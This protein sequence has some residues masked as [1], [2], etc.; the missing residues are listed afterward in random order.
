MRFATCG[1][2]FSMLALVATLAA[3]GGGGADPSG[4]SGSTG[5]SSSSGSTGNVVAT[6]TSGKLITFDREDPTKAKTTIQIAGLAKGE[7]ITGLDQNPDDNQFYAITN[8]GAV[9]LLDI[10]SGVATPLQEMQPDLSQIGNAFEGLPTGPIGANF[11]PLTGLMQIVTGD[12]ENFLLNVK[13]G[14]VLTGKGFNAGLTGAGFSDSFKGGGKIKFAGLDGLHGKLFLKGSPNGGDLGSPI[15]LGFDAKGV[16]GFDIDATNQSGYALLKLSDAWKVVKL[17][18]GGEANSPADILGN[19]PGLGSGDAPS[20]MALLQPLVQVFGLTHNN[21]LLSFLPSDPSTILNTLPVQG[22]LSGE[23]LLGI[24]MRPADGQMYGLTDLGRLL[25]I[26]TLTG[27]TTFITQLAE[28]LSGVISTDWDPTKD[29]LHI[30]TE[31]GKNFEL[32]PNGF[33]NLLTSILNLVTDLLGGLLGHNPLID[34]SA[35]TNNFPGADQLGQLLNLDMANGQLLQLLPL[36]VLDLGSLGLPGGSHGCGF[37][38]I[39]G[40]NGLSL[41]AIQTLANGPCT[42]FLV[43]TVTGVTTQLGAIGGTGGLPLQD[44]AMMFVPVH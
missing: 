41:A 7:F 32:S 14:L 26:D 22:L 38:V 24:D 5:S 28:P 3:C 25:K 36:D 17:K 30:I 6:T 43:D 35:F 33:I 23:K 29:V 16:A 27:G 9:M 31:Q 21:Q 15:P 18:L 13:S 40:G 4:T 1:K 12:G 37:D 42:A 20:A 19:L 39:G 2:Q 44:I 8:Q 34:G 10:I 11:N